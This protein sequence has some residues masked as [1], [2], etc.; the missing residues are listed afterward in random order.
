MNLLVTS[1]RKHKPQ[2]H[3]KAKFVLEE[4]KNTQQPA[5]PAEGSRIKRVLPIGEQVPKIACLA[6]QQS[7]TSIAAAP[8]CHHHA[9]CY[10]DYQQCQQRDL[11]LYEA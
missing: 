4:K 10:T 7:R 3:D 2:R 1:Q 8:P 6:H 11:L 9:P 5:E